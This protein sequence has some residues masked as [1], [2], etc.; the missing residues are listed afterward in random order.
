MNRR[1]SLFLIVVCW[2]GVAVFSDLTG[3]IRAADDPKNERIKQALDQQVRIGFADE[4][5][6]SA[7]EL[8]SVLHNIEIEIDLESLKGIGIDEKSKVSYMAK[9]VRMKDA[10]DGMLL[11]VHKD[12][13]YEVKD[14]KLRFVAKEKK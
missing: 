8:I 9:G 13:T 12:L 4:T 3:S 10:L 1:H 6:K 11:S 14:G 5:L 7:A 2:A